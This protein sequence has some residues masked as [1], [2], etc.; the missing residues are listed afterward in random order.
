MKKKSIIFIC[1][2][3]LFGAFLLTKKFMY[4]EKIILKNFRNYNKLE[5]D[6]SP[7]VNFITGE[8]GA[9]KTNILEAISIT[10]MLKSFRNINDSEIIK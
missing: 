7:D 6:F 10:S 4:I 2:E 1:C 5:I 9:G 8:N 3:I